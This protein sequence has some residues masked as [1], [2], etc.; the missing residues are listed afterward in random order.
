MV[1]LLRAIERMVEQ[2]HDQKYKTDRRR[3]ALK[4]FFFESA[5]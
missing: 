2:N 3:R 1:G 4:E 5:R